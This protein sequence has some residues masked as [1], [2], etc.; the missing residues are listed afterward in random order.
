L[1][2]S[3]AR[4]GTHKE[5]SPQTERNS[6]PTREHDGGI[7]EGEL[8]ERML[9]FVAA[10]ILALDQTDHCHVWDARH[11]VCS[12]EIASSAWSTKCAHSSSADGRSI[13]LPMVI[14][15]WLATA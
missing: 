12:R 7:V 14:S 1:V 5:A 2:F 15:S 4:A 13:W 10:S 11:R 8:D 9:R 6:T 3:A